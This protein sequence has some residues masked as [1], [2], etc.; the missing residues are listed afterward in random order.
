MAAWFCD[1]HAPDKHAPL[2]SLPFGSPVATPTSL[3]P[4][5]HP[6]FSL[7]GLPTVP[8]TCRAVGGHAYSRCPPPAQ[9]AA[10]NSSAVACRLSVPHHAA[11][12]GGP[13]SLAALP[14]PHPTR[15]PPPAGVHHT[16]V[17]P[18]RAYRT[19]PHTW[20]YVPATN[21][22]LWELHHP[23][24]HH[25]PGRYPQDCAVPIR[26]CSGNYPLP[27]ALLTTA[28]CAAERWWWAPRRCMA[29]FLLPHSYA[30]RYL[31]GK[32]HL[33]HLLPGAAHGIFCVMPPPFTRPHLTF[34][35]AALLRTV[36]RMYA[37]T[38][39]AAQAALVATSPIVI[40]SGTRR[41][42]FTLLV[43]QIRSGR[44]V[45]RTNS[46]RHADA[47]LRQRPLLPSTYILAASSLTLLARPPH[48]C[49]LALFC[50]RPR[51]APH[52]IQPSPASCCENATRTQALA[53]AFSSATTTPLL[54]CR[55]AT[56]TVQQHQ[57][58]LLWVATAWR[59]ETWPPL[60][61]RY[62]TVEAV[63]SW[64][65]L[66]TGVLGPHISAW[67]LR[68]TRLNR[69]VRRTDGCRLTHATLCYARP[70]A[71]AAAHAPAR[72]HGGAACAHARWTLLRTIVARTRTFRGCWRRH[73][74]IAACPTHLHTLLRATRLAACRST[75]PGLLCWTSSPLTRFAVGTPSCSD[76]HCLW[77]RLSVVPY[78]RLP[79][80]GTYAA[81]PHTLLTA[82]VPLPRTTYHFAGWTFTRTTLPDFPTC[83]LWTYIS[84]SKD[85]GSS[86]RAMPPCMLPACGLRALQPGLAC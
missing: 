24:Y 32:Q 43:C 31:L 13:T 8:L 42:L 57:H 10:L 52:S 79:T 41:V 1:A 3:L 64:F 47:R 66:P 9:A 81:H 56:S 17:L 75:V 40:I 68:A 16:A 69:S 34:A 6:P 2:G 12:Y 61:W 21:H 78:I 37:A 33:H 28:A 46:C 29:I 73:A 49:R 11:A 38:L 36:L 55:N 25:A 18:F 86:S 20:R 4:A 48:C 71:A 54:S 22:L 15:Y 77:R 83:A 65:Y 74:S 85:P 84:L 60:L 63:V 62:G 7:P 80:T 59:F 19:R 45:A 14:L 70:A 39:F 82:L 67:V 30:H 23:P 50:T 35:T 58:S 72:A 27:L 5:A 51:R 44:H 53:A 76:A 26:C